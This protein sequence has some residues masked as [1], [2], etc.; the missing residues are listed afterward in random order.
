MEALFEL[1]LPELEVVS[2]SSMEEAKDAYLSKRPFDLVLIDGTL[3]PDNRLD[4][5]HWAQEL[6]DGGK[7]VAVLSADPRPYGFT[8]FAM[9]KNIGTDDLLANLGCLLSK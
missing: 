5:W 6:H 1:L 3:D 7:N 8:V 4:G 9:E 2:V